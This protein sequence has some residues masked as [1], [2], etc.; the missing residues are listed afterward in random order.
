MAKTFTD[1]PIHQ[2]DQVKSTN[3]RRNVDKHLQE[4]NGKLDS[5]N[6]PVL[7]VGED[8][9]VGGTVPFPDS[10]G[11]IKKISSRFPSQSYF[12]TRRSNTEAG[13]DIWTPTTTIDL[14]A[15]TWGAGFNKLNN[16]DSNFSGYELNFDAVEGMLVGCAT[17]DWEHGNQVFQALIQT[18][19]NNIFGP[20]GQG[21]DWWTEWAVF[22]NNVLVCR[23]GF[24]Y[25]RRHTTQLPFAVACGSQNVQIDVRCQINTWR[26]SNDPAAVGSMNSSDFYIFSATIWTRNHYR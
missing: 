24:I 6:M 16:L 3:I 13:N 19:P 22:V 26:A 18:E 21:F 8:N 25:P 11:A 14:D 15:D 9:L 23:S 2:F 12:F 1:V 20:L 10:S 4:Y 17:I 7:S 5:N